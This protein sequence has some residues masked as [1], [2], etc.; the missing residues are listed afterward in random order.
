MKQKFYGT[1]VKK[2]S[3]KITKQKKFFGSRIKFYLPLPRF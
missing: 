3:Y 2:N 1:K